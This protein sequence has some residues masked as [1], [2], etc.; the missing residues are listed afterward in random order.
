MSK[1]LFITCG[2][3]T[4]LSI[5]KVKHFKIN[6]NFIQFYLDNDMV[7]WEFSSM[8]DAQYIY[9]YLLDNYVENLDTKIQKEARDAKKRLDAIDKN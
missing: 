5:E 9:Q 7:T 2:K 3:F 6:K 8:A 4:P 1:K